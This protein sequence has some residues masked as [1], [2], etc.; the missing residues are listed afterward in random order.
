MAI[1][2][3][4]L[5]RDIVES[6]IALLCSEAINEPLTYFSE[7]DLQS[8]LFQ[9]LSDKYPALCRTGYTR[10]VGKTSAP[11]R[12]RLVHREYGA[13]G[14]Q[15]IDLVILDPDSVKAVD[16]PFLKKTGG[17]YVKPR[18]AIELGTEKSGDSL[19]HL[20]SDIKKVSA[21]SDR[22][23]VVHL[24]RDVSVADSGT[25]RRQNTEERVIGHFRL[26]VEQAY[27]AIKNRENVALLAFVVRVRRR[28]RDLWGRCQMFLPGLDSR[29]RRCVDG[30]TDWRYVP[31]GCI[32]ESVKDH[33]SIHQSTS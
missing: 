31:I 19:N 23:Y 18:Y 14:Q 8:R 25:R 20:L 1:R 17:G 28:N 15:R 7:A 3:P 2:N 29:N 6:Q 30:S 11:F 16:N 26:A 21:A 22:G 12:T 24:F 5:Q 33:L 27:Q 4:R 9:M 13:G 10:G 32:P